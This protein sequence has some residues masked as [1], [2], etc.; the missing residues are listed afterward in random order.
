MG[1]NENVKSVIKIDDVTMTFRLTDERIDHIKELFIKTIKRELNYTNFNALE[2][3]SFEIYK[4]ERIGIIG[5]NGAGKSTLLKLISGIMKPTSGKI[6]T[7]GTIAPLLELGA[8][9]DANISGRKNIYLNGAIMGK[10]KEFLEEKYDEITDFADIGRFIDVPLKNYSSGMKARL[11][12]SIASQIEAD[13]IILDEVLGVGDKNFKEKS[14]AKIE[15]L[16]NSGK[17]II[18]VS[19]SLG[20]IERLTDRVIWLE[21]GKVVEIGETKDIV[22][23]Y[24]N[25]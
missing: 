23:K 24:K 1:K 22:E 15:E 18:L 20:E 14:S 16:I 17:T 3:V 10:S 2:N 11:G 6:Y 8:G 4:G 12:F 21:K 7:K 9:F 13:I 5:G 25:S 19:H